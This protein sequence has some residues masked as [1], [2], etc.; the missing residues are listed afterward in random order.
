VI[1][2]SPD[3]VKMTE[4]EITLTSNDQLDARENLFYGKDMLELDISYTINF[5]DDAAKNGWDG[6][7]SFYPSTGT[8]RVSMQTNPYLCY[9]DMAGSWVD[10]NSPGNVDNGGTNWAAS[11]ETGKD[12]QVSIKITA[13]AVRLYVDGEEISTSFAGTVTENYEQTILDFIK[14]CDS[15]SF[16]VGLA[17]VSFWNTELCTISNFTAKAVGK[18]ITDLAGDT[19]TGS[20]DDTE[21]EEPTDAIEQIGENSWKISASDAILYLDNPVKGE[22]LSKLAISYDVEFDSSAAKN[23]WDGLFSFY[24]PST[25]ARVAVQSAPYICYNEMAASDN[26]WL[27]LNKPSLDGA[28]D[29]A[30]SAV[31][32]QTYHVD[33]SITADS[34][35]LSVDG[36]EIAF[37]ED[38]SGNFEGYQAMLDQISACENL[39]IGVGKAVTS[40]WNTELCTL[41][42]LTIV[43]NGEDETG[44]EEDTDVPETGNEEDTNVPET[45]KEEDTNV[46]E[47]GKE[48]DTNVPE[49]GNDGSVS[50]S[51]STENVVTPATGTEADSTASVIIKK[52]SKK[53]AAGSKISLYKSVTS[54]LGTSQKLTW[55]SSNTKYASVSKKGVVTTKKAGVGKTVTITAKA[56]NGSKVS[57]KVKLMSGT[58][59]K[60]TATTAKKSVKAGSSIKIKTSV[61]ATKGANKTLSFKSSN[62]KYATVSSK[63]VVKT[64]KA[65][66]GKTVK[67]TVSATDGSGKKTTVK[68]KI[69]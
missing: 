20:T 65:G 13:D 53:I 25:N 19:E 69:K 12:Y 24:D 2:G 38:S 40:F 47:T 68:I 1:A 55:T 61:K 51:G 10:L 42:N 11:A 26:R 50:V 15:F 57:F 56:A 8:G 16:G 34:V 63:G 66:A 33:I 22:A 36:T 62:T 60:V 32:G 45:G 49:T 59:Q 18:T 52:V 43:A 28:T 9:N 46:P 30:A 31:A 14:T 29:W 23:G 44:S 35:T 6:I 58:V 67:I 39:T 5:A 3:L 21:T 17:K 54:K 64:K 41:S 37:A 48:E 27:D 4:E 7:F